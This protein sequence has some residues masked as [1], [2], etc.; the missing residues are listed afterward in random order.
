MQSAMKDQRPVENR[1]VSSVV[2]QPASGGGSFHYRWRAFLLAMLLCSAATV[3]GWARSLDA[4]IPLRAPGINE[5]FTDLVGFSLGQPTTTTVGNI[6][7]RGFAIAKIWPIYQSLVNNQLDAVF[8]D[9]RI[10]VVVFRPFYNQTIMPP[11]QAQQST[12][13][14]TT[15]FQ[16]A[17]LDTDYG[18]VAQMLYQRYGTLNKTVILTGWESDNQIA[19]WPRN[20]PAC[21]SGATWPPNQV[22]VDSYQALLQARQNGVAA[23]RQQY[24]TA[25]LRVFHAVELKQVPDF[26]SPHNPG[27]NVLER[28]VANMNPRPDFLSYSAWDANASKIVTKLNSIASASGL[29]HDRIYVGEWGCNVGAPGSGTAANR[30]SCFTNHAYNV[31]NWGARMWIVWAYS[32]PGGYNRPDLRDGQTG[33]DTPNGFS[34]IQMIDSTWRQSITCP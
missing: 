13:C 20:N 2:P 7:T 25:N 10:S 6:A 33:L 15:G 9:S 32:G 29:P 34:V 12:I 16:V 26:P 4:C 17:D 19:Y 5:G 21:L 11:Q 23:A 30:S 31:F 27:K 24:A 1:D 18:L 8:N 22:D 3:P 14:G 28:I